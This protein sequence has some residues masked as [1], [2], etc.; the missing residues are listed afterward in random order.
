MKILYLVSGLV[1]LPI[2]LFIL[3]ASFIMFFYL[4]ILELFGL[5]SFD[6]LEKNIEEDYFIYNGI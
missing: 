2:V 6:K 4:T 5:F 1:F 3:I